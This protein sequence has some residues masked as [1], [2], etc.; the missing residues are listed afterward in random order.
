[1]KSIGKTCRNLCLAVLVAA[2]LAG[3]GALAAG[4]GTSVFKDVGNHW[5]RNVIAWAASNGI[6][7]GF[8]DGTFRPNLKI[9]EP[10]FLALVLRA[11][12]EYE[13]PEQKA[14]EPWHVRYYAAAKRLGWPVDDTAVKREYT[15]GD[16]A[17]IIAAAHGKRLT[18]EEAVKYLLDNGFANGK[19]SATPE[20]FG[21]G[22]PLNRAE[23]LTFIFNAR[24][25]GAS[26][27]QGGTGGASETAARNS[28]FALRGIVIG[29]GEQAVLAALGE[30]D[31][32]E[33]SE[34]G[35]TWLVYNAD[36]AGF[37]QIGVSGGRVAAL[38]S[39]ADVWVQPDGLKPGSSL[40]T[41]A[42]HAGISLETLKEYKVYT[43]EKNGLRITLYLD[44]HMNTVEGLLV[45]QAGAGS[46]GTRASAPR[47][48]LERA[49]ERQLMDLA[50]VFRLKHGLN[51]LSWHDTA[52]KAARLHSEDMAERGYFDHVNPDGE[53][54]WDRMAAAGIGDYRAY[55][56]NIA[57]GYR[58]A[59]EAHIGWVNSSG[60]RKNLLHEGFEAL[61]V[62]VRIDP[63]SE[64]GWY[65]TQNFYTPR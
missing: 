5:A 55:G 49:Y 13:V 29:D 43:Y 35:Y 27:N 57:A 32:R 14:G 42:G 48:E 38:F 44:L 11:F 61:G 40:Q 12:P 30:P 31:R 62:G 23:A 64:Y 16:A 46:G 19:T 60:H 21:A 9:S 63:D 51:T 45:E 25:A 24:H 58:N 28:D 59:F 36:Y 41:A 53:N 20:G 4:E 1:M 8:D 34:A 22:D 39:N 33:P 47:E 50:N 26:A 2:G 7:N 15:R 37:A 17:R 3:S 52:A 65:Y 18:V 6:A 10:E 56:E 54:P